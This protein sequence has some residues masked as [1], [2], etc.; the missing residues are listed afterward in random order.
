MNPIKWK[1]NL[2]HRIFML[3]ESAE[4]CHPVLLPC[5]GTNILL[6][7]TCGASFYLWYDLYN[8]RYNLYICGWDVF[9]CPF[10]NCLP[11]T[12]L[13]QPP[14]RTEFSIGSLSRWYRRFMRSYCRSL[15]RAVADAAMPIVARFTK[16][17]KTLLN[18]VKH[19]GTLVKHCDTS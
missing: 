6:F 1:V 3:Y 12:E 13:L 19:H 15:R 9:T 14:F 18:I 5:K 4:T 2:N 7:V 16:H 11:G 8:H 17:S 10:E